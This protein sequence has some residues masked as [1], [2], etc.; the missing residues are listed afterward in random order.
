MISLI[1][2][3]DGRSKCITETLTSA[4]QQLSGPITERIIINDSPDPE[5]GRM[6]RREYG[7]MYRIVPPQPNGKKRGFGGAIQAAWAEV[8]P[9]AKFVFHLEDDFRFLR[10]V[11]LGT[12]VKALDRQPHIIQFA[13]LRQAW[14]KQEKKA[15]GVWQV[16]PEE[17]E[18]C[19]D[20]ELAVK[21]KQHD[22]FFTTNP[23]LYRR[24]LIDLGWPDGSGSEGRFTELV[25]TRY[26]NGRFAFWGGGEEWVQHI[27]A[28]RAGTGY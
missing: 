6:L 22:L 16:W 9:A 1:V 15:G 24:S 5:F 19:V 17:Y 23:S 7:G 28:A 21:W 27:G 2:L 18:D 11:Q 13:L 26:P 12:M 10:P 4:Q 8:D 20:A 3:T 14:S 25:K